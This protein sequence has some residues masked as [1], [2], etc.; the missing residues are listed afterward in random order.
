MWYFHEAENELFLVLEGELLMTLG[1]GDLWA[2]CRVVG[3]GR[4]AGHSLQDPY[5][6]LF[7]GR[8]RS[9]SRAGPQFLDGSWAMLFG[10]TNLPIRFPISLKTLG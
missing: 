4:S 1:S 2:D 6:T 9:K 5:A 8:W 3:S 10:R 7:L